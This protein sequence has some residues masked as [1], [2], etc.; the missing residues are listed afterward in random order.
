MT[1][2]DAAFVSEKEQEPIAVTYCLNGGYTLCQNC[3]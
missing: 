2:D 1:S 3:L